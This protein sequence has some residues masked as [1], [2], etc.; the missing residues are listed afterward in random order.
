MGLHWNEIK[1]RV[2]LFSTTWGDACNEDS[3]KQG[4]AIKRAAQCVC[5]ARARFASSSLVGLY[6]PLTMPTALRKAHHKLDAD[7]DVAYMHSGATKSYACDAERVGFLFGL[8]Q[9]ITCL[10]PT[11]KV[12]KSTRAKV[13][14]AVA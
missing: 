7:V 14:S 8:Y 3:Y 2:L 12:R 5:Y 11:A 13:R 9:R 10:L 6:G 4:S 1:S